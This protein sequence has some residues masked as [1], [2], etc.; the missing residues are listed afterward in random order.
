MKRG[1]K[2][3]AV[4][5][6]VDY[7]KVYS[8]EEAVQMVKK[9]AKA[10]FDETVEV[11]M[12][13]GVDPR[14]ADQIV[15]GTVSLPYGTG[16]TVKVLVLTK[17]EKEAEARE[18]GADYVGAEEYIEKIQKGW[19][20]FDAVVATPDM[21]PQVGKLARILGPRKMMP[22][23]K[24][25][26]VTMDVGRVVKEIKAGKIEYRVD[27]GGNISAPVGKVSFDDEKLLE[28]LNV[29]FGAII[30]AKPQA[31]KGTYIKNAVITSTMG[32]GYKLNPQRI[33]LAAK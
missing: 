31:A 5:E 29:F 21:M 12:R 32:L 16:K 15:R 10:A 4:R 24:S 9:N 17:G 22:N 26:T 23:P 7:G 3:R 13:L 8:L 33:V 30:S 11:S 27:R 25:G 2:Y 19:L 1:K 20:D 18:A 6:E 28:N 14:Q